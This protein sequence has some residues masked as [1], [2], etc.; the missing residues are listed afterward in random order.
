[1][2]IEMMTLVWRH[3][4]NKG[5][6]LLMELAIADHAHDDGKGA[7]P[8]VFRL[9]RYARLSERNVQYLVRKLTASKEVTIIPNGG[10][11]G[12]NAFEINVRLLKRLPDVIGRGAKIAGVQRLHRAQRLQGG[13]KIAPVQ[14]KAKGVQ[15][16]ARGVQSSARGVQKRAIHRVQPVAPDP[17]PSL[18]PSYRTI[19]EPSS[20]SRA[21]RSPHPP[22]QIDR[23]W[24]MM[25]MHFGIEPLVAKEIA[26]MPHVTPD[27]LQTWIAY[28][29]KDLDWKVKQKR[30][31]DILGPGFFVKHLKAGD[32][33]MPVLKSQRERARDAAHVG[34][35]AYW[36]VKRAR[37][38]AGQQRNQN[39]RIAEARRNRDVLQDA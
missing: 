12:T 13:A 38:H 18:D 28:Q 27:Y 11:K 35:K 30:D 32:L 10:P 21:P 2:S 9:T 8:S 24:Q 26:E 36:E 17:D 19:K 5:S 37:Q 1:M 29:E 20:S 25:M 14:K 31:E 39:G 15:S 7:Y 16:S 4:R 33:P 34:D 22:E 6:V 23:H 3:S